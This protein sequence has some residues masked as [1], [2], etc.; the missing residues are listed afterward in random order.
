V[1]LSIPRPAED[2]AWIDG[3]LAAIRG[4]ARDAEALLDSAEEVLRQP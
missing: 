3:Q 1:E 2:P 4:T